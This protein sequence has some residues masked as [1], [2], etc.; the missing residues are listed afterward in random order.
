MEEYNEGFQV[1]AEGSKPE[2]KFFASL[3]DIFVDPRKVFERIDSGLEW[4]KGFIVI[5]IVMLLLMWAQAPINMYVMSLN[6]RGLDEEQLELMMQNMEKFSFVKYIVA[7]I[8][9]L[10]IYLLCALVVNIAGNLMSGRS[11]YRKALGLC[12]F[13]GFIPLVEQ[14]ISVIIIRMRGV[15]SI[16]SAEDAQI[17]LSLAPLFSDAGNFFTSLLKSLSIFS[18]WYYVVLVLGISAIYR[19]NAKK[20]AVPAVILWIFTF[21]VIYLGSLFGGGLG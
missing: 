9:I 20:S 18:I 10:I 8:M 14:I 5:V 21:L 1:D 2:K 3:V 12:T 19:I 13:A 17:S 15:E 6:E 4:W 11:N 16:Q 7:P